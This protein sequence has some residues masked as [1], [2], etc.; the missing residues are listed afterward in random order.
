[1]LY[2]NKPEKKT[3]VV[4]GETYESTSNIDVCTNWHPYADEEIVV[5]I[6]QDEQMFIENKT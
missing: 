4:D 2:V 3:I 6:T 1:M 5:I